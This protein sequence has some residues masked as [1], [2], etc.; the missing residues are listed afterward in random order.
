LMIPTM[1]LF[2]SQKKYQKLR[3]N[4][5]QLIAMKRFK[6]GTT[7]FHPGERIMALDGQALIKKRLARILTK[8]ETR[9]ILNE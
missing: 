3:G 2:W 6:S 8:A 5:L 1:F 9:N 7:V 4:K